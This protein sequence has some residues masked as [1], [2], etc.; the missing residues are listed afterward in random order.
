VALPQVHEAVRPEAVLAEGSS[1]H[2]EV[3]GGGEALFEG[4]EHAFGKLR[5]QAD[6]KRVRLQDVLQAP[7][8][9]EW[10]R[11]VPGR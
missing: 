10:E 1:L 6:G 11:R 5:T 8:M 2:C 3:R 4:G 7:R 9:G